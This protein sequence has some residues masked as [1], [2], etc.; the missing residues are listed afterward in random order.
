MQSVPLPIG[1][2]SINIGRLRLKTGV[3]AIMNT[4]VHSIKNIYV[5]KKLILE[6]K[7]QYAK[8]SILIK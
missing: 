4:S 3:I 6:N 5:T 1:N 7:I 2:N 8:L